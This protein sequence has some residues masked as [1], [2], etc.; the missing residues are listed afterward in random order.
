M[1]WNSQVVTLK[2]WAHMRILHFVVSM[3]NF[4]DAFSHKSWN[5]TETLTMYLHDCE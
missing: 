2:E 4:A 5:Q 3:R 1:A